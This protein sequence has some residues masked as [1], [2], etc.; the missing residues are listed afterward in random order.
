VGDATR[1]ATVEP[2]EE[3]VATGVHDDVAG[4]G[5]EMGIH[6]AMALGALESAL[7]VA[8][9]GRGLDGWGLVA[10]SAQGVN[11]WGQ[12]VHGHEQAVA[13]GAGENR[14]LGDR[15]P[16]KRGTADRAAEVERWIGLAERN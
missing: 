2:N 7:E 14:N 6:A 16:D 13:L 8:L 9:I 3:T 12:H 1:F 4:A 10:G 15:G 5:I 11:Q